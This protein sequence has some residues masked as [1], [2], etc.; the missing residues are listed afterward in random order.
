MCIPPNILDAS[1]RGG[2]GDHGGWAIEI[3]LTRGILWHVATYSRHEKKT[4]PEQNTIVNVKP[5]KEKVAGATTGSRHAF[6]DLRYRHHRPVKA[7]GSGG[8]TGAWYVC[9]IWRDRHHLLTIIGITYGKARPGT[10]LQS[11]WIGIVSPQASGLPATT[12][13][14]GTPS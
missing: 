10:C 4:Y 11:G 1:N 12:L 3:D 5:H 6:A 7:R 9:A 2:G 8:N 14:M 13:A